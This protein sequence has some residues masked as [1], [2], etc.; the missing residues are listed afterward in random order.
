MMETVQQF[1]TVCKV[2]FSVEPMSAL[3]ARSQ[4]TF[5]ITDGYIIIKKLFAHK[6]KQ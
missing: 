6:K 2:E 5:I 4:M 3:T 1:S